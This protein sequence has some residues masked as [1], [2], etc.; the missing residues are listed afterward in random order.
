[1]NMAA[2]I[3]RRPVTEHPLD[4]LQF[5]VRLVGANDATR[6]DPSPEAIRA[7]LL[8]LFAVLPSVIAMDQRRR[9]G[10]GA[11]APGTTSPTR[12]TSCT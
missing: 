5:A 8:R 4:T 10:L 2:S 1:M 7:Q 6:F 9:N 11:I 3:A 12:P